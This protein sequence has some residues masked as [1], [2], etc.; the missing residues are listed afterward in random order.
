MALTRGEWAQG[1]TD[2]SYSHRAETH[3]SSHATAW[4]MWR[5]VNPNRWGRCGLLRVDSARRALMMPSC[6]FMCDVLVRSRH[7][8]RRQ[9][10][11]KQRTRTTSPLALHLSYSTWASPS[12]GATEMWRQ[13]FHRPCNDAGFEDVALRMGQAAVLSLG[14]SAGLTLALSRSSSR[15]YA[16]IVG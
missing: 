6:S 4:L 12:S 3:P 13:V 14:C 8:Y 11:S 10:C 2:R 5:W 7:W 1:T 15:R 9:R 16:G